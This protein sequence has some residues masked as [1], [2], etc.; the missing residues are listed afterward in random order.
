MWLGK[1]FINQKLKITSIQWLFFYSRFTFKMKMINLN[2]FIA[3]LY[4]WNNGKF[5]IM[6]WNKKCWIKKKKLPPFYYGQTPFFRPK[7]QIWKDLG[8]IYFLSCSQLFSNKISPATWSTWWSSI[9]ETF[10]SLVWP[11]SQHDGDLHAGWWPRHV[12]DG[13]PR[14]V[15][16]V[17]AD[18]HHF[19]K[20]SLQ[21]HRIIIHIFPPF[22]RGTWAF[23]NTQP[24]FE[25]IS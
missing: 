9:R 7:I 21:V 4:L 23:L 18:S 8:L 17:E 10:F 19:R 2:M 14:V 20:N 22:F 1:K 25:K 3:F 16:V 13:L 5:C 24:R 11:D 12:D 6:K 15:V